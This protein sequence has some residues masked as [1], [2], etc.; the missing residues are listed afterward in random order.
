MFVEVLRKISVESKSHRKMWLIPKGDIMCTS[1]HHPVIILTLT[2]HP[3]PSIIP[4]T[5][6]RKRCLLLITLSHLSTT[7]S[8][9]HPHRTVT[10][11]LRSSPHSKIDDTTED[12]GSSR[13]SMNSIKQ[14][15]IPNDLG[16]EILRGDGGDLS[17]DTWRDIKEGSPGK[18]EIVKNVSFCC[19][20]C[21]IVLLAILRSVGHKAKATN[22]CCFIQ[23]DSIPI[24][25]ALI[26]SSHPS[27]FNPLQKL[28]GINIFT[29][30]LAIFIT[31]FLSM[32]AIYGPGWLGQ[33]MGL[34][35]VGTFTRVSDSLPIDL[36]V[37]GEE[38]LL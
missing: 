23:Y 19:M 22:C 24:S 20:L 13:N 6:A 27:Q 32:N 38:F 33:S 26:S 36:D 28:M 1:S 8:F 7:S 14:E 16:L 35:D 5:M 12:D 3:A 18:W 31:F 9:L 10:L 2:V 29:Y 15:R 11:L 21:C 17:D 25:Q 37:S 30:L 34:G 4:T